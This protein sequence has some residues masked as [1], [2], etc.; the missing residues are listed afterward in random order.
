MQLGLPF[1]KPPRTSETIVTIA[2]RPVGVEF[3]RHRGARHYI[4]RVQ[5]DGSL[6]VTVPRGGSRAG[7]LQFVDERRA[8]V[9]RQRYANALRASGRAP[10]R[11]GSAIT[12][13][14]EEYRLGVTAIAGGRLRVEFADQSLV[15]PAADADN[16]RPRVEA[17]MRRRAS[18]ELPAR[19]ASLASR[20][21]FDVGAVS[22]RNQRSRWGSCSPSGRI[23]LNWRLVLFPAAVVDYVL[24]HELVHLRHPNHSTRFWL[25]VDRLCPGFREAR[26]WLRT[27]Q[28][29]A[30]AL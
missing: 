17:Q 23:S 15:V 27:R 2:G 22:I 11:A 29:E 24:V 16:L 18:V 28:G 4:L 1:R 21:G 8:W 12:F 26:A 19:L 25:E 3:V 30:G 13:R 7:A 9:E 6:R 5:A 20:H 14:G 10:W